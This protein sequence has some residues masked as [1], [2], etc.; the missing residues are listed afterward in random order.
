[1]DSDWEKSSNSCSHQ[2]C[3]ELLSE[4]IRGKNEGFGISCANIELAGAV[5]NYFSKLAFEA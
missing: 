2:L 3:E 1:M 5:L 4:S